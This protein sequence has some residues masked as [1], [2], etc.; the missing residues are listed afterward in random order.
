MKIQAMI[1]GG[2]LS[3]LT[4]LWG[5]DDK[6]NELSGFSEM[7]A[8]RHQVRRSLDRREK[9]KPRKTSKKESGGKKSASSSKKRISE[10]KKTN[11]V[12]RTA[13]VKLRERRVTII[14]STSKQPLGKGT[15]FLNKEGRIV[16]LRISRKK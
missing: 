2:L 4:L 5:C 13:S 10:K 3:G 8:D 7:V 6:G 16:R 1:I 9:P 12:F 15:A 14:D 11:N